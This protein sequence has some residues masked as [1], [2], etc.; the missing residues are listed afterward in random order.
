MNKWIKVA[1]VAAAAMVV[2]LGG[3]IL[4]W[5]QFAQSRDDD[6]DVFLEDFDEGDDDEALAP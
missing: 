3:A 2:T 4:A 1:T 6:D 5:K